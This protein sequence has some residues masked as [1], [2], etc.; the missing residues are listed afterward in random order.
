MTGRA[1]AVQV[2]ESV[3]LWCDTGFGEKRF[4][5]W[6]TTGEHFVAHQGEVWSE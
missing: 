6:T 5:Q 2:G 3:I 4:G 1:L